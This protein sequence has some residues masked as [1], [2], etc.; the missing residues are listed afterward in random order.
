MSDSPT[1]G[2]RRSVF[3]YKIPGTVIGDGS[4]DRT[5][6][7]VQITKRDED[8]AFKRAKNESHRVAYEIAAL[9]LAFIDG[10]AV[11]V[12]EAEAETFLDSIGPQGRILVIAAVNKLHTVPD[13]T[14]QDFL[15]AVEVSMA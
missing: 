8:T 11:N 4:P 9:S 12:A 15:Q 13:E 14:M 6:G 3:T 5:I 7:L 2:K 1:N 10:K